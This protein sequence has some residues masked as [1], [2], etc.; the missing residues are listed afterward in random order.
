ML[1]LLL[2]AALLYIRLIKLYIVHYLKIL[3][4]N[5]NDIG[6]IINPCNADIMY[7]YMSPEFKIEY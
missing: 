3:L 1:S 7:D 6:L 2:R 4:Y 5:K